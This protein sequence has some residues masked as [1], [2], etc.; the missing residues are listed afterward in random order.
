MINTEIS[1]YPSLPQY[2][3]NTTQILSY[4]DDHL[5]LL[6]E[7]NKIEVKY[8][9]IY[10]Y[11][12][13]H[14]DNK[15]SIYL[16]IK[17]LSINN[18]NYKHKIIFMKMESKDFFEIIDAALSKNIPNFSINNVDLPYWAIYYAQY[19]FPYNVYLRY[20][21]SFLT[22]FLPFSSAIFNM[23]FI[24]KDVIL[25]NHIMNRTYDMIY[26]IISDYYIA[27]YLSLISNSQIVVLFGV[28]IGFISSTIQQIFLITSNYYPSKLFSTTH[29]L[30]QFIFSEILQFYSTSFISAIFNTIYI[31]FNMVYD[32]LLN[33]YFIIGLFAIIKNLFYKNNSIVINKENISLIGNIISYA[34]SIY[35][36]IFKDIKYI[37]DLIY[38]I[39]INGRMTI[40]YIKNFVMKYKKFLLK[41]FIF[42]FCLMMFILFC[43]I[44]F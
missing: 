24:Y 14:S 36:H 7:K 10:C 33:N 38:S 17:K 27:N 19:N 1:L 16:E 25:V 4:N 31:S 5:T 43:F 39:I 20:I 2:N 44:F 35:Y 11:R 22:I 26:G 15:Y 3:N 34:K 42:G 18:A 9:N 29:N 23:L 28:I 12:V 13:I 8:D 41:I 37:Y 6:Q 30:L 21:I 32:V 40:N